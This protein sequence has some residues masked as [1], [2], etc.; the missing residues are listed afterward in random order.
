MMHIIHK[1]SRWP[2]GLRSEILGSG[3]SLPEPCSWSRSRAKPAATEPEVLSI[4]KPPGNSSK[5]WTGRYELHQQVLHWLQAW[6]RYAPRML[7]SLKQ[8]AAQEQAWDSSPESQGLMWHLETVWYCQW[9]YWCRWL[10]MYI[11]NPLEKDMATHPSILFWEMPWTEE[12][13]KLQFMGLPRVRHDWVTNKHNY[14]LN[15]LR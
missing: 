1:V 6:M 15:I 10:P 7:L 3:S 8:Q 12:P 14:R 13:G 4:P 5:Q 2:Q 11:S 9:R